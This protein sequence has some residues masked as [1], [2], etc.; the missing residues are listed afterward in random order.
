MAETMYLT[1]TELSNESSD[2]MFVAICKKVLKTNPKE[3][4]ALLGLAPNTLAK[5]VDLV[6][7]LNN[8]P[9]LNIELTV[10]Y[11]A[12]DKFDFAP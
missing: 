6:A 3:E 12:Q 9:S 11:E 7:L 4:K 8:N 1:I 10:T 2:D 5:G